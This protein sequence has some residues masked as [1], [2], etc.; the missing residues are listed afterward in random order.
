MGKT[1][2]LFFSARGCGDFTL[3]LI[4]VYNE[5]KKSEEAFEIVFISTDE[6]QEAFEDY[7]KSMPWLAL[8]FGDKTGKDLLLLFHVRHIPSLVVIGPDGKTV[9]EDAKDAVSIHGAE[10]YPFTDAHLE[11]L[12]NKMEELEMEMEMEMEEDLGNQDNGEDSDAAM[13]EKCKPARVIC[14]GDVCYKVE[15]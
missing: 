5:L 12:D 1:V 14:D 15:T 11:R 10:A 9:T 7:Y 2:A 8:P 6:N 4:N 3:E 13:D